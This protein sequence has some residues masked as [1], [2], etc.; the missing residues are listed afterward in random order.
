MLIFLQPRRKDIRSES[1][2]NITSVS[3][4]KTWKPVQRDQDVTEHVRSESDLGPGDVH[5]P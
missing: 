3:F 4:V 5:H 2:V 1:D